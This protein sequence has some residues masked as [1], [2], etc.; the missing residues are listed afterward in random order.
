MA[1]FP[2]SI[3]TWPFPDVLECCL[4]LLHIGAQCPGC[5]TEELQ[6]Q[7]RELLRKYGNTK[8]HKRQRR[9]FCT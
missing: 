1:K 2:E 6:Q 5:I 8:A 4:V 7:A 9:T 3:K